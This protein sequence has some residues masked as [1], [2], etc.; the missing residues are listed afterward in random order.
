MQDTIDAQKEE[1][2]HQ[3]SMIDGQTEKINKMKREQE[4]IIRGTVDVLRNV[5]MPEPEIIQKICGLY[6]INEKQAHKYL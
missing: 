4:K 2:G 1:L 6:G 3:Q 5:N